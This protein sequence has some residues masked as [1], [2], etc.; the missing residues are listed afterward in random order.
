MARAILG[1]LAGGAFAVEW[2]HERD[3]D[4]ARELDARHAGLGLG[5]VDGIVVALRRARHMAAHCGTDPPSTQRRPGG[6]THRVSVNA[7]EP[8]VLAA[9]RV[10]PSSSSTAARELAAALCAAGAEA[11]D[12]RDV[13]RYVQ[14]Q[15]KWLE[16]QR[17]AVA[18]WAG[19]SIH[20]AHAMA[21]IGQV[22]GGDAVYVTDGGNT[23]MWAH[24]ALPATRPRSYHNILELGMLGTGIPSAIGA[25]LGAPE[26]E[27]VCVTGDSP[28]GGTRF[29]VVVPSRRRVPG[30]T[31]DR[32]LMTIRRGRGGTAPGTRR[33]SGGSGGRRWRDPRGPRVDALEDRGARLRRRPRLA[34][35]EQDV[36]VGH[37]QPVGP[38]RHRWRSYHEAG[39]DRGG[40]HGV[41][42]TTAAQPPR[43]KRMAR[44][45]MVQNA[46]R[47]PTA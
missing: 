47:E 26:R 6:E 24:G 18:S 17:A 42:R 3:L 43:P 28:D 27:V 13:D 12:A 19:P 31:P 44:R 21:V 30:W 37:R 11:C 39:V 25:K 16:P 5:L 2:G 45:W 40:A 29:A 7:I 33:T 9:G 22:F 46:P 32:P 34:E 15:A 4:R 1:D 41:P 38:R 35:D 8:N 10:P 36:R 14:A 23:S 20:P